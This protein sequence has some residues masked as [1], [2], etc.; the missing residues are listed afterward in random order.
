M[1]EDLA[2]HAT[3][4]F[5]RSFGAQRARSHPL[6]SGEQELHLRVESLARDFD[7]RPE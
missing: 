1:A 6:A 3:A 2:A 4:C 5:F 7:R